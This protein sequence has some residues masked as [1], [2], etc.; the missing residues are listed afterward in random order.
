M[1][2][3]IGLEFSFAFSPFYFVLGLI[4]ISGYTY[5][6]YRFTV[7]ETTLLFKLIL[8]SLRT[9]A[10]ILLLFIIFEP[11]V[12]YTQKHILEPINLIFVDNSK[13]ITIEDGT[14]R[15]VIINTFLSDAE[16]NGIDETS[17][18]KTFGSGINTISFDKK[19]SIL[20]NETRTNFS[21][22]F[23]DKTLTEEN[24]SSIIIISDGVLTDGTN[25]I[26]TSERLR[27]PVFTIGVGDTSVV[28]DIELKNVLY[29]EI[30]YV[31]TP[32]IISAAVSNYG[33]NGS[34]VT[35]SLLENGAV[36]EQKNL[37]L[38]NE[39]DNINFNYKPNSPGEKKMGVRVSPLPDEFTTLNNDKTFF[40]NV[41]DEK[42]NIAIISGSPSSDVTFIRNALKLNENYN[43]NSITVVAPNQFLENNNR[44]KIVDSADIIFLVGFP[45]RETPDNFSQFVLNNIKSK[46]KPFFITLSQGIDYSKLK[47]F[48]SE[49]PF[50]IGRINE[51]FNLVQPFISPEDLR[52]PLIQNN[53][54]NISEAWRNLP[55]VLQSNSDFRAKPESKTIAKIRVNNVT[56]N[57]P[58]IVTKSFGSKKSIAVL[59][60]DIWRW[61]LQAATRELDLFDR[62]L[63]NSVKWLQTTDEQK[64]V[65]IKTTKKIYSSGEEVE[66]IA[67][68]YDE[69]FAPV[70]DATVSVTINGDNFQSQLLLESLGSGLYEGSILIQNSGDYSF[71]GSASIY[72]N[73]L[74]KDN[75]RFT[76]SEIDIE[77]INPRA[78]IN[79]LRQLS[80]Q[81][82]GEFFYGNNYSSLFEQL[83]K[84][85]ENSSKEKL[86][87]KEISL[88][89]N[90]WLAIII[91][92]LLAMEWFLRK[93]AGML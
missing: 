72:G 18:L 78:D 92:L 24:I 77:L 86:I 71:N 84:I 33:Y 26:F 64:Q 22:I 90:E 5:Y 63:N 35:V 75:G 44:E 46:N 9:A 70:S 54:P 59:A 43:I 11:I 69:T 53:S 79:F 3:I 8:I 13:S 74:G 1:F 65:S 93:R 81:T 68:V 7:P 6:V 76:I 40:V 67:Q 85:R 45:S 58:L 41:L 83:K 38:S 39:I 47:Q 27:I 51:D 82:K 4:L 10:L 55:P 56:L 50:S 62:F 48:E 32:S 15:K 29:N 37:V 16:K 52:N 61:K 91:I 19:D 73:E 17:F 42:I 2:C 31:E 25:P 60:K 20:F 14:N 49:L 23:T 36:I 30:L 88:W 28:K 12:T 89:S 87:S 80:Y 21:E 34:T 57:L 66:F